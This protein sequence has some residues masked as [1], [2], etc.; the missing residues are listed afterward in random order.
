MNPVGAWP[1]VAYEELPWVS[2]FPRDAL[3]RRQ[4]E[5]S[6]GP[7]RAAIPPRIGDAT[8]S[9]SGASIA[10]ATEAGTLLTRFDAEVGSQLLPFADVLLRSEA[11]SSSEIE[12]LTS[13]ARAIAETVL[14]ERD[15]GNAGLVVRNVEAMT[16]AIRLADHIDET[17][18]VA[19]QTA[20]LEH[21]APHLVGEYRREQ[22]WIGG[23]GLSPHGA[24]FVPPHD[25]RVSAAM[26]D[27][28]AFIRRTDIPA[29]AHAALAH[30]Q[31]ETIHPF[32]DGNG[33]TGRALVQAM[34]RASR[35]TTNVAVPVSAG[36]L[37]D[38]DR[39]YGALDAYRKGDADGIVA[40]FAEAAG[41]AV[42]DGR[43]LVEDLAEVR[44]TW[45][46]A[47]TGIRADASARRLAD[48]LF[49]QP[50]VNQPFVSAGLGVSPQGA[51][52]AIGALVERGLLASATSKHR[53][54]IWY[55]QPI[56]SALDD[57]AARA[58]RRSAPSR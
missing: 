54:R 13:G 51:Y 5:Q 27:L 34:L 40:V 11:A 23:G 36:L 32:P 7:Y 47:L 17:T 12:N 46:G 33:R 22:V 53:N 24:D 4:W 57:F 19:M 37:H 42:R 45:E 26:G 30:A 35:V 10:D 3:S 8:V 50:V 15:Q 29:L 56:L 14:G 28:V 2:R 18:I 55:A 39:Y 31:F 48:L 25:G 6:R 49:A 9:L 58:G 38:V 43:A 16:A 52:N 21:H 20:L 41:Y 1:P 44:A